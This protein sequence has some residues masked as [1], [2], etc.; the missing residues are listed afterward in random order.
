MFRQRLLVLIFVTLSAAATSTVTVSYATSNGTAKA[1]SDYAAKSGT[2]TFAA[3][4]TT[5]TV[6]IVA[7]G[8]ASE[9][10]VAGTSTV[11]RA[12]LPLGRC[13]LMSHGTTVTRTL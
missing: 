13:W 11:N 6:T 12:V 7:E 8:S 5:K 3:G 1:G 2:L 10:R 4:E 9:L